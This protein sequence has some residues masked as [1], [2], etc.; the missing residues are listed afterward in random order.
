[1]DAYKCVLLYSVDLMASRS[2]ANKA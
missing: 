2:P 1:M